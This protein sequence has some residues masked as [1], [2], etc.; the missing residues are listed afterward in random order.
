VE[1]FPYYCPMMMRE[2]Y[3]SVSAG[4]AMAIT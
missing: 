2:S 3:A 1:A 4:G